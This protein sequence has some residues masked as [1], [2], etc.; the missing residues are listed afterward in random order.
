MPCLAFDFFEK[1][2]RKKREEKG[3]VFLL[4]PLINWV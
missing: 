3:K 4:D 1:K 2:K